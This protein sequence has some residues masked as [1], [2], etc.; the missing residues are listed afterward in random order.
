MPPTDKNK[1]VKN[2]NEI[3]LLVVD[4]QEDIRGMVANYLQDLGYAV[5]E[6]ESAIVALNEKLTKKRFDLVLSDIN[7]PEMK[8]FELLKE[9][10]DRWPET[11]RV[12]MTAYNVEDYLELA[13]TH[14]IGNIFV[15]TVPFNFQ[16]LTT[17]LE[18]LLSG[19]IFGIEKYFD[20][21]NT[22]KKTFLIKNGMDLEPDAQRIVASLPVIDKSNKIALVFIEIL[23]NAIFYGVRNESADKKDTWNY[24]FVL[25][26]DEA[27]VVTSMYDADKFAVSI[28]DKGGRL[29]KNDVLFW[30]HRQL[31]I[32]DNG[33]PLGVFDSH[34][35]GFFIAR[36]YIDRMLINIDRNKQTEIIIMN[37]LSNSY[38]GYKPLYINEL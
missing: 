6:A 28:L 29:K 20:P 38:K 34:G 15:K 7:M 5:E 2:K 35:R 27:I 22:S 4:D 33:L 17:V 12:L 32:D 37:F 10:R 25:S 31:H 19:D 36:Q 8:G 13:M 21:S 3:N 16:E 26:D 11:K 9:I 14:D 1:P 30:L 24:N 18:K 23:A